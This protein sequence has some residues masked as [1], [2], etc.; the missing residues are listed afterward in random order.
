MSFCAKG[1]ADLIRRVAEHV[2][3]HGRNISRGQDRRYFA[4]NSALHLDY[5]CQIES[6]TRY[7]KRDSL[8]YAH[9]LGYDDYPSKRDILYRTGYVE[10]L[11]AEGW[12]AVVNRRTVHIFG[13]LTKMD[14]DLTMLMLSDDL[15]AA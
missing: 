15:V 5:I 12:S 10:R 4:R 9:I 2:K 11:R 1:Q 13:D 6:T 3:I 7:V 8:R 14:R